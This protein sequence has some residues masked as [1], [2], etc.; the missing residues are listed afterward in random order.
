VPL[1]PLLLPLLSLTSLIAIWEVSVW[2]F[3]IP[4]FLLPSPAVI[5]AAGVEIAGAYPKHI[6]ATLFTVLAGF[7]VSVVIAIPLGI[8][9]S[10]SKAASDAFYPLLVFA[11]AIPI[12]AVAPIIVVMF[13]T[14]LESRLVINFLVSFF[15]LMVA[16]ATGVLDTP[17]GYLSLSR[18]TGASFMTELLTIR[19]P[20]AA[21]FIFSGLK[22]GIT[23]SVIGA[24]VGEFITSQEGLGYLIVSA[25]TNFDLPQAMA[26]VI[27]LALM[28]VIL[29][30][31][32]QYLQ[33]IWL[34]W[35]IRSSSIT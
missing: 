16:T 34:P 1:R 24:V 31:L 33:R 10:I 8:A 30:Q 6:W 20:H 17:K 21:P 7:V 32:I 4:A 9:I 29:Y 3:S 12:I 23:L 5:W 35:S 27:V 26:S 14:G 15:P 13:G 11:N 22:I 28:S 2:A 18:S 25:T 19:L